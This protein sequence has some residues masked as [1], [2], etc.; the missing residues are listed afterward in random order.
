[1]MAELIIFCIW[2]GAL[3]LALLAAAVIYKIVTHSK[4]SI[5]WILDNIL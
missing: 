1:M 5:W 4:K 2:M 3:S